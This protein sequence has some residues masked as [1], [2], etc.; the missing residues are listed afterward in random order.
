MIL[1]I[2]LVR[3]LLGAGP[4]RGVAPADRGRGGGFRR[5]RALERRDRDP[6]RPP[7]APPRRR[8]PAAGRPRI[9]RP[10]A[11]PRRPRA[12]PGRAGTADSPL[13]QRPHLRHALRPRSAVPRPRGHGG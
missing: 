11:R 12:L 13:L 2:I 6:P 5:A 9:P 1:P 7:A 8:P 4:E 10:A 3:C